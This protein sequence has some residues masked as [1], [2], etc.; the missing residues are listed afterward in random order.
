MWFHGSEISFAVRNGRFH[1]YFVDIVRF[2]NRNIVD[3]NVG[4][5]NFQP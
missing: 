5:A 4:M 1:P 3:G 2:D